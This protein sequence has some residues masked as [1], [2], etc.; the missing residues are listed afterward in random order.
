MKA[1]KELLLHHTTENRQTNRIEYSAYDIPSVEALVQYMH[2]A[3][4]FPVKS[5]WLRAT[6]RGNFESWPG[7]TYSN[8]ENYF[9]RAVE[10]IK[11][12]KVQSSPGVQS[13]KKNTPT[14]K[15]IKK[16]IFEV[17]PDEEKMEDIPPP[18]K[19]KELHIWDQ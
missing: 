15:R 4:G 13:I 8:A 2:A 10:T 11:G 6:K 7:L 1:T 12:H 19:T 9:P 16:V 5:T 18:I 17:A 14:P 3:S